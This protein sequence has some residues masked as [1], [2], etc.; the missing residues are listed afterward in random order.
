MDKEEEEERKRKEEEQ[1]LNPQKKGRGMKKLILI[2][3]IY[4]VLI[5]FGLMFFSGSS[6]NPINIVKSLFGNLPKEGL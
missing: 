6:L 1:L 4:F 5:G 2:N 3:F